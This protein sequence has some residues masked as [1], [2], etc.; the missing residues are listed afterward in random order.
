MQGVIGLNSN[1]VT[2]QGFVVIDCTCSHLNWPTPSIQ[3]PWRMHLYRHGKILLR[4]SLVKSK[5]VMNSKN[6]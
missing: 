2:S 1:C 3:V 4:E 5:I 6:F